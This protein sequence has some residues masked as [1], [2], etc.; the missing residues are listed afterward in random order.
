MATKNT[1]S[2]GLLQKNKD[3]AFREQ[4]DKNIKS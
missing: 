3:S 1:V 4:F 2:L